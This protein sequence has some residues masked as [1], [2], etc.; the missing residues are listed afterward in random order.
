MTHSQL[1]ELLRQR[2]LVF[3]GAMGTEIYRRHVFLNRCYEELNLSEPELV[4]AIHK[5]YGEAGADVFTTNTF[6][7]NRASLTRFGLG[8]K[9]A[10]I[11]HAGVRLARQVAD[12]CRREIWIAG[13]VGPVSA[14]P[15]LPFSLEELL[16]EQVEALVSAGVDFVLFETQSARTTLEACA[17][18]MQQFPQTAF[19]L[20]VA[21]DQTGE[22]VAGCPLEQLVGNWPAELPAP[23][24]WGLNCGTGP[25]GLLA[26]AERLIRLTDRPIIVQPNA[27]VPKQVDHRMIYLCSPEYF[28]EYAKRY[29]S[30]GARGLGG[31]CGITPEHIREMAQA[32]KPLT[33][34]ARGTTVLIQPVEE[35]Q[36]REPVPLEKR[37]QLGRRLAHRQWVTSVELLPPRGYDLGPIIERSRKLFAAGV[38]A[39]NIPDGPR[40]SARISPLV[41]AAEIQ[42][43]VG[44]ETILHFCCRDRNLIGMQADLLGCAALGVRNILFVTGDPP[45]LGNYPHATAV[46]DTDSIGM[47]AVQN[48]LNRGI[49]LGGQPIDPPT[50]AVIGVGVDPTAVDRQRELDRFRRKIEAGAEFAITQP[51]F[52]PEALLRFLDQLGECPIPIL[53]GVWPLASLKN[54]LFLKNEVPGVEIPNWVLDRL[55]AESTRE[56]QIAAGIAI[57]REAIERIAPRVAGIQVSAPFGRVELALAVLEGWLQPPSPPTDLASLSSAR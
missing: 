17:R 32:V 3:D 36:P 14:S 43:N 44:I 16:H 9:T 26:A 24:A 40:A 19:V 31:C 52:D 50:Q 48:R 37:S 10:E 2:V 54:A 18:V 7:A 55:A 51:V 13:S 39:I 20:S 46:F 47:V 1:N 6:A 4:R 49:D 11:N 8:E 41:T 57:A 34:A 53:A 21:V 23:A 35:V 12:E 29:L 15:F 33:R 27:G 22:T 42:R 56:G 38:T 25:S 45:K 5:A 28:T 30:I